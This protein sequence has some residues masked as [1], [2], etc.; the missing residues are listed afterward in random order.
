MNSAINDPYEIA[1]AALDKMRAD[2]G[3]DA[4][5]TADEIWGYATENIPSLRRP[6]IIVKFAKQGLISQTKE[7]RRAT[8]SSR[9][10]NR[11]P[12]YCF[13]TPQSIATK[14]DL[15]DIAND[16][17]ISLNGLLKVSHPV[18][19]RLVSSLLSKHFL[20][21]T[22]LA[23]SGKTKLAQA[24]AHWLTPPPA[25][26]HTPNPY[27]A[28]VPV[29]A[30]WTS[31]ENILGYPDGLD[32]KRYVSRPA[33][34]LMLHAQQYLDAPHFLILDEMNLSHVERYFADLLS[35]IES[36]EPIPL[37]D[38]SLDDESQ[39]RVANSNIPVPPRLKLPSNLFV[40]GTVNVDETTYLFS[41]KVL[42]RANVLEFRMDEAELA[43]FL[44]N[45]QKPDLAELDGQGE[46]FGA[47]F[48]EAAQERVVA[49][50]E[51]Q[52]QY[53]AEIK[54]FFNVLRQ[55]DAEFGYRVAHEAAR[56]LH[57]Y[58]LLGGYPDGDTAWFNAA[59]DAIIVQKF[60]PKLHGSRSRLEGLLWALAQA[61]GPKRDG[62]KTPDETLA[63]CDAAGEAKEDAKYGL[64]TMQKIKP[65]DALYPLSFDKVLRMWRKLARDQFTSFAEA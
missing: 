11:V 27:Y 8:I 31:N 56:F 6:G 59:F 12:E 32:A 62:D 61:C 30:D 58:K 21:N 53:E 9:A 49:P 38:G 19:L 42:D 22:G 20:I 47:A 63:R 48:V 37:Y 45:P 33:L 46:A 41:P 36:G 23:G 54:L 39:W 3:T 16:L 28:L 34:E 7:M 15:K 4:K 10:G 17:F 25:D 13:G 52:A 64:E 40:I 29:G 26:E 35:A 14:S 5:F 65:A 60:L 44:A 2:K 57:F 1:L 51:A 24:F 18:C 50:A 43:A 55:H